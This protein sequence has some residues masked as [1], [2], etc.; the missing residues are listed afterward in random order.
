MQCVKQGLLLGAITSRQSLTSLNLPVAPT[1]DNY[2]LIGSQRCPLLR[3]RTCCEPVE[4]PRSDLPYLFALDYLELD[5]R[6]F[7]FP[8]FRVVAALW[9][10][11]RRDPPLE[12][13]LSSERLESGNHPAARAM[14][15]GANT[16]CPSFVISEM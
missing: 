10:A 6:S 8:V 13:A 4:V 14:N 7:A 5:L 9:A 15:Q 12:L 2:V 11:V 16:I 1:E 3:R